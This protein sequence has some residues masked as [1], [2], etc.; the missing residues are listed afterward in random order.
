LSADDTTAA[1]NDIETG[2]DETYYSLDC[3]SWLTYNGPLTISTEADH[4]LTFWSE[5]TIGNTEVFHTVHI[6]IDTTAPTTTTSATNADT[7]SYAFGNWTNQTATVTLDATDTSGG[8]A[9]AQTFYTLDTGS[10]QTYSR[11]LTIS[12]EGDHPLIFWSTDNAGNTEASQTV[13][14]LIDK[15]APVIT[16]TDNQSSYTVDQTRD[17][18][19]A[20][21]DPLSGINTTTCA[22]I[23]QS[24]ASFGVGTHT[25]SASATDNAGN[26]GQNSVTFTI[27]VTVNSL[28]TLTG[29]YTGNSRTAR[30]LCAPLQL[31]QLVQLAERAHKSRMK[32]AAINSYILLLHIQRGRGLTTQEIATLTQLARAL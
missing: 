8:S 30:Q 22:D 18:H 1:T 7:S 12:S 26:V 17:I 9:V 27:G 29:Q 6:M 15:S 13:H 3:G 23:N 21:T 10:P 31:V 25:I 28:C 2:V 19:C 20:A 5:D 11:S 32:T 16:F 4:N 14:I 24:A